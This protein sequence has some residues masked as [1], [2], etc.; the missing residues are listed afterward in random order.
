MYFWLWG[1]KSF[2]KIN[3]N[4]FAQLNQIKIKKFCQRKDEESEKKIQATDK[5]KKILRHNLLLVFR[6]H[7]EILPVHEKTINILTS[8]Q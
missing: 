4:K 7:K 3:T 5:K 8:P 6:M 1:R 2:T